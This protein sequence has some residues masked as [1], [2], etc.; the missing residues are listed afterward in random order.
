MEKF[1][2]HKFLY[3]IKKF[4]FRFTIANKCGV[5]GAVHIRSPSVLCKRRRIGLPCEYSRSQNVRC[6]VEDAP[7]SLII[8]SNITLVFLICLYAGVIIH[9]LMNLFR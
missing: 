5:C 3:V 7:W 9:Y 6:T 2:H 8:Y 1:G 4:L